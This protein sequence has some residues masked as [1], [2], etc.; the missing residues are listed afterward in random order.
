MVC[1]A[2]T[3]PAIETSQAAGN[4]AAKVTLCDPDSIDGTFSFAD[5]PAGEQTVSLH[6][7]NASKTACL[8]RGEPSP[9]FA[10]DEHS[11]F[12]NRCWLLCDANDKQLPVPEQQPG[13][14]VFLA[15]D[16]RAEVDLHWAMT[17]ESCQ[18]ADWVDFV[19]QWKRTIGYQF[20]PSAWPIH[21]C[22]PVR[23]SGYKAETR[24]QSTA[25]M[26]DRLLRV[27]I[28]PKTLYNDEPATLHVEL[29]EQADSLT[30]STNCATLYIVAQDH[31][32]GTRF[33]ALPT[34]SA[35][36][37]PSNTPEQIEE[38]KERAWPSWKKDYLRRCDIPGGQ[39][40]ADAKMNGLGLDS[41]T[42][43]EWRTASSP[44][45][46][47]V[48]LTTATH[49]T[50]LDVETLPPNW[51]ETVQ[52]I[53]A[54]LSVD[55]ESYV[56]G[57]R[58]PLRLRWE[59][60]SAAAPLAAGEC[61]DPKPSLEIQDSEHQ[62]LRTIPMGQCAFTH[63]WGPF[64]IEK[65]KAARAF[66]EL[67]T[68]PAPVPSGVTPIPGDLPGPGVYYLV[69]VWSAYAL[70]LPD[71]ESAKVMGRSREGSFGGLYAT[72]RSLPVR[73]EILPDSNQ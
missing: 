2:Q 13:N 15:P 66:L 4:Y 61:G 27:S 32:G 46:A 71:P 30:D 11:M 65:G 67:T 70:Q 17:G 39:T 10:V 37:Q 6:F 51:G 12:V 63:G 52:G 7:R 43:I 49:F 26:K 50:V 31:S 3:P 14:Q 69:S 33:S 48:F 25:G 5:Q 45:E 44:D 34:L 60:V 73:V 22:S 38:D 59:N 58:V 72:A 18:W 53:H 19:V 36:M 62:V 9:T 1:C 28:L 54:G 56:A 40:T 21:L 29:V 55:R 24:S 23:S 35:S 57:E 41:V 47:P 8:L 64:A 68:A 42:H 20:I 16:E